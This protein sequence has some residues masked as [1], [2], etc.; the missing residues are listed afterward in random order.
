MLGRESPEAASW[1]GR[2]RQVLEPS[3]V[4]F[5]R[6]LPGRYRVQ[7]VPGGE[8]DPFDGSVK[9]H[10]GPRQIL[11]VDL[12][13]GETVTVALPN[14]VSPAID[15]TGVLAW[16]EGVFPEHVVKLVVRG[17]G[18]AAQAVTDSEGRF[19]MHVIG[20]GPAEVEVRGP[21]Q[22]SASARTRIRVTLPDASSHVLDLVL[23]GGGIAGRVVCG[24]GVSPGE[25]SVAVVPVAQGPWDRAISERTIVPLDEGGGYRLVGLEPGDYCV[26][27]VRPDLR[28]T[29]PSAGHA[30]AGSC[31]VRVDRRVVLAPDIVVPAPVRVTGRLARSGGSEDVSSIK[32]LARE[33]GEGRPWRTIA[34]ARSGDAWESYLTPGRYRLAARGRESIAVATSSTVEWT[35]HEGG[36]APA[37]TLVPATARAQIRVP[38]ADR[39]LLQR[40]TME[41]RGADGASVPSDG[42]W[43]AWRD[44]H[45]M[46]WLVPGSY[47]IRVQPERGPAVERRF[48]L[49]AD[50]GLELELP[51]D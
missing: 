7:L 40:F 33:E 42:R 4:Q 1:H 26:N 51:S 17:T 43:S 23:G 48:E 10:P 22:P 2:R 19:A 29:T 41:V 27:V 28:S 13:K 50:E 21:G 38:S 37:L 12:G 34:V 35:V 44:E 25:Q 6:L 39:G 31:V 18:H 49:P 45:D 9:G 8:V 36:A 20:S 47:T 11:W 30:T 24:P 3:R 5:P 15:V 14:L 32:V 16:P 46:E